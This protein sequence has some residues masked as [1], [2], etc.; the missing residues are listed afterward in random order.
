MSSILT[1]QSALVALDTLRN[2]NSDLSSVQNEISTGKSVSNAK[3]N[4][5]IYAISTVIETDIDSFKQISDSLN[6][7]SATVGVARSASEQV[8]GLLQDAQSLIVSAQEENVDRTQI[9]ASF[10]ELVGNINSIVGAAQFNGQNLLDSGGSI[11]VLSSLD[12]SS[13]GTVTASQITV[14]RQDLTT[15]AAVAGTDELTEG[16]GGTATIAGGFAVVEGTDALTA[17]NGGTATIGGDFTDEGTGTITIAAGTEITAGTTTSVDIDGETF[18]YVSGEGEGE[19]EIAAGLA[20]AYSATLGEDSGITVSVTDNA[21]SVL[22]ESGADIVANG[23]TVFEGGKAEGVLEAGAEGTITIDAGTEITEGTTTSFT[24]GDQEVSYVSEPGDGA[25]EIAAALAAAYEEALGEDSDITVSVT[26]NAITV[27]NGTDEALVSGGSTV[28]EGGI[29]A[30][31]LH[32]LDELDLT[33]TEGA[34]EALTDIETFLQSAI[35]AAAEFGSKQNRIENQ[36]DFLSTLTD[37]LTVGVGALVD[38]DLE[39]A[40]ARLQSLQVQQQLGVQAL[41]IANQGPQQ[42]L[43]LFR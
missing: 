37:S 9:Q 26:D 36:N 40:S 34:A 4:S 20:A 6:L 33:T 10:D 14:D 2:I 8:T 18:T 13:D 1:N 28:F 43:S 39:E 17:G 7:G 22:N 3:D 16:N 11:N 5:A 19:N 30:G 41:S 29:Q 27:T 38:A 15:N 12:R 31:A 23:A 21:I 35:S 25:N 42:L 32:G 24:I